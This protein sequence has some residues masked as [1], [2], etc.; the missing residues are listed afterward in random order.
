MALTAEQ[1]LAISEKYTKESLE[2]V[3]AIAGK[4]CQIQSIEPIT[5]GNRVTFLWEDNDG[6]A[7]T[8][9]MDVMKGDKGDKGDQGIQGVQG[10][11]GI[12]GIQGEQGEKGDKG[13]TGNTGKG[14][15]SVVLNASDHIIITYDDGTTQDAGAITV[16]G[17]NVPAENVTAGTLGGKV[18]ANATSVGTLSNKQV[19]NIYA[20]TVDMTAGTSALPTGDIYI[21]YEP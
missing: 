18:L 2:G 15:A 6:V 17:I 20:G 16:S 1:V 19:R 4:P 14:I 11:Q 21:F 5:G 3:G 13:D 9:T 8:D 10:E 12:Q 7:H